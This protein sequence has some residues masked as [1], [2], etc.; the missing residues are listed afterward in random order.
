MEL[1]C[2]EEIKNT[3]RTI[4]RKGT[5]CELLQTSRK[6]NMIEKFISFEINIIDN[7][8]GISKDG[9]KKLF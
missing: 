9:L 7:G 1:D 6:E 8:N 2:N 5:S 4:K 3:K